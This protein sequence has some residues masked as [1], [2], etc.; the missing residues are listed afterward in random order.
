[1]NKLPDSLITNGV[2]L[3]RITAHQEKHQ[4][5]YG[6]LFTVYGVSGL[7]FTVYGV[8]GLLFTVYGSSFDHRKDC[9]QCFSSDDVCSCIATGYDVRGLCKNLFLGTKQ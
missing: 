1:M 5:V 6:L 7:L 9:F 8:S 3:I 2:I 4:K